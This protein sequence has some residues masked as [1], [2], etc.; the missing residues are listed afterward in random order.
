LCVVVGTESAMEV[1]RMEEIRRF[2]KE[3]ETF[4]YKKNSRIRRKSSTLK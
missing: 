2:Y 4:T 3:T 1:W